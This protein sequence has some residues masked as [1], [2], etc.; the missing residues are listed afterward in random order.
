MIAIDIDQDTGKKFLERWAHAY[1]LTTTIPR[2]RRFEMDSW[3]LENE[4]SA[5]GTT[6][7]IAGHAILHPWFRRRGFSKFDVE[8]DYIDGGAVI[9]SMD[10]S[11]VLLR[12]FWGVNW[13]DTPFSPTICRRLLELEDDKKITPKRAAQA[14]KVYMLQIWDKDEVE[15][16]IEK[17]DI[18]YNAEYVHKYTPWE[19]PTR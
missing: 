12:N 10:I 4:K 6:A 15:A 2:D 19:C 14:I 9:K 16:A 7:C 18:A 1:K 11:F 5:C 8:T 13:E 17:A 3:G